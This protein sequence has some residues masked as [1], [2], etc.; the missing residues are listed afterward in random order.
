MTL[1][2]SSKVAVE[3]VPM[4]PG[5]HM[6]WGHAHLL[7]G[8]FQEVLKTFAETHLDEHGRCCFWMGPSLPALTVTRSKDVQLVLKQS[9]QHSVFFVME[10]HMEALFG[11][12]NLVALNGRP[13]KA[14]RSLIHRSLNG[15]LPAVNASVLETTN[16]LVQS[17]AASERNEFDVLQLMKLL[18]LDV[19]GRA[20]MST[21]LE[22]CRQLKPSEIAQS[23]EVLVGDLM[24]R[25]FSLNPLNLNYSLPTR[26]NRERNK[27]YAFL[28]SF[29]DQTIAER[30]DKIKENDNNPDLLTRLVQDENMGSGEIADTFFSLLFAGYETSAVTLCYSLYL[31]VSNKEI[32]AKC[33]R[34]IED[35]SQQ[36]K[37]SYE[38]LTAVIK[39]SLRLYPP[40]VSTTRSLE[41]DIEIDGIHVPKGTY[42]Y[43]PIWSIHR[44]PEN[45]KNPLDFDPDRWLRGNANEDALVPFSAGARSCPGQRFAMEEMVAALS[46]LLSKL[47][48]AL[49]DPNYVLTPQREQSMVQ[50]PKNGLRMNITLRT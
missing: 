33:Q 43:I 2:S 29:V 36:L 45:F 1:L 16:I 22:C 39:E 25:C 24:R 32:Y 41:K 37:P 18:A 7:G 5:S 17:I 12:E 19:F 20:A 13:W 3:G 26:Q 31:I 47:E 40:A 8:P 28:K 48:F 46:S 4:I 44:N 34:E 10:R 42:M 15:V 23:F 49:V 9:S 27:H 30:K 50:S 35:Q 11:T 38:L 21:D 6:L 14:K